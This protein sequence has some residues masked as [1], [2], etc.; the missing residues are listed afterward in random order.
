LTKETTDAIINPANK[1][2]LIRGSGGVS[3]AIYAN[4]GDQ[5]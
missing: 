5:I 3:G 2:L 4:G 1:K